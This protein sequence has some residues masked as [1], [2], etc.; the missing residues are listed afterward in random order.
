M[1]ATSP[2]P[3]RGRR[4]A[5][6]ILVLGGLATHA[7]AQVALVL[8]VELALTWHY[9]LVWWS[10]IAFA[11]G[12]VHLRTGRS[13][14]LDRPRAFALLAAWSA[15]FWLFFEGLNL[16]LSNWYYVGAPHAPWERWSGAYLSFATVLPGMLETSDLLRSFGLG[17]RATCRPFRATPGRR[18]AAY[19]LGALFLVTPLVAPRFAFPLV[20]GAVVLLIE[21]FLAAR[22]E[23]GLWTHLAAGRAHLP[24]RLLGAGLVAGL[25]WEALNWGARARW[26]YTVP[27]FEEL[28]LFEMPLPGFLGFPPFALEGYSFARLLVALRLMPEWELEAAPRGPVRARPA[29]A[30]A[31]AAALLLAAPIVGQM[32]ART[33]RSLAVRTFEL[34][35]VDAEDA[36]ALR[37]AGLARLE[38]LLAAEREEVVRAVGPDD[39]EALLRQAR[40]ADVRGL[41]VRGVEW[42]ASVDVRSV[43][44]LARRQPDELVRA[45]EQRGAGPQ[46][47][48]TPAEARVWLRAAQG[49]AIKP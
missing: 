43:E 5:A 8:G 23:R 46:P 35:A 9:E 15:V 18:R 26:I 14:L 44:E 6:W 31:A 33:V 24:L 17:T 39:A 12:V 29:H 40:L 20:W 3:D 19:A 47:R 37:E 41:G 27:F 28:K 45:L 32:Q 13:M 38:D 42:L 16:V 7:A 30:G 1:S 10:Y 34:P 4:R 48:P 11:D 25:L 49:A 22:G 36:R 21:P 2:I